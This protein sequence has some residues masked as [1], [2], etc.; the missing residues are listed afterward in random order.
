MRGT[1]ITIRQSSEPGEIVRK[2]DEDG[3]LHVRHVK[4]FGFTIDKTEK[5]TDPAIID[6]TKSQNCSSDEDCKYPHMTCHGEKCMV[7]R[8]CG[9]CVGM[10]DWCTQPQDKFTCKKG[11][12]GKGG[13][14]HIM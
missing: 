13:E 9:G 3:F 10:S 8:Y 6:K 1:K 11:K 12:G 7:T 14:K 5:P 2:G 4:V